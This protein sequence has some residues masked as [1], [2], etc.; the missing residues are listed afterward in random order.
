MFEYPNK[1]TL[2]GRITNIVTYTTETG[3]LYEY[4]FQHRHNSDLAIDNSLL[5]DIS[6]YTRDEQIAR[7]FQEQLL[8]GCLDGYRHT[9]WSQFIS[10]RASVKAK[11]GVNT[12]GI[13]FEVLWI[14]LL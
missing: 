2:T 1:V 8:R 6:L 4:H 7:E 5:V 12:E 14:E 9:R 11:V 10:S 13:G 3:T